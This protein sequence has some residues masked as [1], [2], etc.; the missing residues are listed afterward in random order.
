MMMA[1]DTIGRILGYNG[2]KH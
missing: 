1:A 2:N